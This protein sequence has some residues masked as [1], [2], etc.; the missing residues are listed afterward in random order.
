LLN[1]TDFK[2]FLMKFLLNI[3][4]LIW[5]FGFDTRYLRIGL[6]SSK[7]VKELEE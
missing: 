4:L 1:K 7:L 3:F 2:D 5:K 6:E